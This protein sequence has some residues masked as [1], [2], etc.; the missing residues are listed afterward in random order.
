MSQ[1]LECLRK[2][3]SAAQSG[4]RHAAR[5][6]LEEATRLEPNHVIGW[7]WL[8]WSADTPAEAARVLREAG[9]RTTQ[10]GAQGALQ[11][12]DT[13]ASFHFTAEGG[14]SAEGMP[15]YTPPAPAKEPP[16]PLSGLGETASLGQA[17][18]VA[19][20]LPL[21]TMFAPE[22]PI[23]EDSGTLIMEP[24]RMEPPPP[25]ELSAPPA[26]PPARMASASFPST[27]VLPPT[28]AAPS[29]PPPERMESKPLPPPPAPRAPLSPEP[30][31]AQVYEP[32]PEAPQAD[33]GEPDQ[34]RILV[35]DD[36]PTV[37]KIVS[38]TLQKA[39]YRV[40]TA[41]DGVEAMSVIAEGRPDLVLLDITMPRMDGYQLCKLIKGYEATKGIPV[42][43]L[44]GKDGFFDRV[45]GRFAGCSDYITKPFDPDALVQKVE[46]YLLAASKK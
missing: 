38:L 24:S 13:L 30:P 1:F 9:G 28:P 44:S 19:R 41:S 17:A 4:D 27:Q 15:S 3:V 34:K 11:F 40:L 36:S 32:E 45:R 16:S 6:L 31:A 22:P 43:M 12:A 2:G 42:V 10:P 29:V 25:P 21:E 18:A 14:Y 8:A 37:C 26:A 5:Q 20:D 35:V 33:W 23:S 7:L 46:K 39:G